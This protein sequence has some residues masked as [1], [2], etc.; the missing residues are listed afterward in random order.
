MTSER[1]SA[2]GRGDGSNP[3]QLPDD[4]AELAKM[5]REFYQNQKEFTRLAQLKKELEDLPKQRQCH[6]YRWT[7]S[8][9]TFD[10]EIPMQK[11]CDEK[12]LYLVVEK[13][14]MQVAIKTDEAF[15]AI[16]GVFPGDVDATSCTYQIHNHNNEPYIHVEV[17]KMT[18]PGTYE[19]W[20]E[21][22]QGE[23]ESPTIRFA[24]RTS[25]YRWKQNAETIE[26]EIPVPDDVTK[27]KT[28]L[29]LDPAGESM[30]LSFSNRPD[31]EPLE[32]HFKALISPLDSVWMLDEGKDGKVLAL[33]IKKRRGEKDTTVWWSGVLEGDDAW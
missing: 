3:L 30:H 17:V 21:L 24:G 8:E 19:F 29:D 16:T 18:S 9:T 32:G 2:G 23:V 4:P 14:Q 6:R 27:R 7:Q 26:V 15:G 1:Q 22:L 11:V 33:T 25:R 20:N 28:K 13:D 10:V 31:F 5:E 12:D